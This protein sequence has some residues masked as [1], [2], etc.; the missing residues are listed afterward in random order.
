MT[1]E[2][3]IIKGKLK[4]IKEDPS[5]DKVLETA[6][7]G[8]ADIIVSGDRHLLALGSYGGVRV[9][10]ARDILSFTSDR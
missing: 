1:S 4:V 2:V 10:R 5:D 6:L 8:E 9:L 7:L 3:V